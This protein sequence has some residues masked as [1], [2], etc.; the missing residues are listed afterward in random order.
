MLPLVNVCVRL[1]DVLMA[2]V[3]LLGLMLYYG[4]APG[5]GLL[6]FPVLIL[7]LALLAF[8]LSA[9]LAR[10]H[11]KYRDI[12]SL[13]AVILQVW[14]FASPVVYPASLI[15]DKWRKI[16]FLNPVAGVIENVRASLVGLPFDWSALLISLVVT[17][18]VASLSLWVFYATSKDL[19]D[20]F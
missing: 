8:A 2:S 4:V 19:V 13:L 15:G 10:L 7:Q 6:M 17:L 5:R 20:V 3:V 12:S 1:V 11:L 9:S 14:M 16:Y 18:A